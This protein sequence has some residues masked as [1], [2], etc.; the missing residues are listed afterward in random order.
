M[1]KCMIKPSCESCNYWDEWHTI[2][3]RHTGDV[4]RMGNCCIRSVD[5]D[6]FPERRDD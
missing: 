5:N 6:N 1:A 3:L 2:T 4:T